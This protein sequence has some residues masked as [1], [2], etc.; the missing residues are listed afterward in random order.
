MRV[1]SLLFVAAAFA[2]PAGWAH[3]KPAQCFTT[4]DGHYACDFRATDDRGS[5]TIRARGYP[6]YTLEVDSPGYTFGYV[7]FGDRNVALPGTFQRERADPAC[8]RNSDTDVQ[9]CA[10]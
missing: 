5:F 1:C 3:A 2:L 9:V 6:T 4:D 7:N 8:W 10:W